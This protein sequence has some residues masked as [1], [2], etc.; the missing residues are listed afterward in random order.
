[1]E[2]KLYSMEDEISLIGYKYFTASHLRT[3]NNNNNNCFQFTQMNNCLVI[4]RL[5]VLLPDSDS[6][7]P[8]SS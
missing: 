5:I 1:M 6:Y 7:R 2:S 8:E 3:R 4:A